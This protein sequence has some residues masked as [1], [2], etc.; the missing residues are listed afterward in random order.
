MGNFCRM[1]SQ[2]E[3]E[4]ETR[5]ERGRE[6]GSSADARIMAILPTRRSSGEEEC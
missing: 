4:E 3:M 5:P 6:G 2:D 1:S